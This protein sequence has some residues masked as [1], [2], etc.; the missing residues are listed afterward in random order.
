MTWI[1]SGPAFA[2]GFD[3]TVFVDASLFDGA[4]TVEDALVIARHQAERVFI[5]IALQEADLALLRPRMRDAEAEAAAF[6]IGC[7]QR[8]GQR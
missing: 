7:R 5:G 1:G 3:G 4:S 6:I 8:Q 2:L